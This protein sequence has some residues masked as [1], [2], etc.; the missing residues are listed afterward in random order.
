MAQTQVTIA[1]VNNNDMVVMQE[2]SSKFEEEN[3][4][5]QLNW[6]ILEE[7]VLRQRL[8][9]DIATGGGQFDILTIG[10]FETPIWGERDWLV[11][12]ENV[13]ADYDL[14]DVLQS[15]RDGLSTGGKLY[16]LPFY[17]ES[18][19]TFY[20]KDL[21]DAAGET[22]PD[23]PTWDDIERIAAAINDP[24][25]DVYGICLRGKPGWGENVGQITPV[26]NSYGARWFDM[27]W[28]PQLT[29]P[30]WKEALGRYVG[31]LREYGPPGVAS[32]GYNE[33]LALFAGGHCGIWVDATVSAGFLTNPDESKVHDKVGYA[34]P[35]VGKYEKG[36]HYLWSWALAVP[37][38]SKS[39][40]AAQK[41]IYWATSKE[42]IKL[43]AEHSGWASVPPGTRESTYANPNYIEAAP[44]AQLTFDTIQTADPTDATQEPVPY[45]GISY[46]GIPEFQSFGT[47]V[48][49]EFAAAIAGS[50]TVEE[51]LQ[52]AQD[53]TRTAMEQAGYIK[54]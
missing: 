45:V 4:D 30:E 14:D 40:E 2:L 31:L 33:T 34:H 27:D 25:N 50:K 13:P 24:E 22:M 49:Q 32:N 11:P 28:E 43:V 5:I 15:V 18:Q 8:T 29:S 23:Q 41:F 53:A 9:T 38:S 12:F 3:P 10:L 7:N 39:A 46:V 20:R 19:M 42:Y 54:N 1:T 36:N 21:L 26:A 37:T 51:A 6:V 48:G 44:F 16:A 52:A 17:A 47:T 35:P